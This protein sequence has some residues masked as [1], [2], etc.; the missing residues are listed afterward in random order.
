MKT[1]L[2]KTRTAQYYQGVADWTERLEEAFDFKTPERLVKFVRA[3]E[4]N[5][6]DLQLVFAFKNPLYN[7][8]LPLD[9]RFGLNTRKPIQVERASM[10]PPPERSSAL[11]APPKERPGCRSWAQR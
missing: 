10:L 4:I 3:A 8:S 1:L 7:L 9:E 5:P 6:E 2:K 11:A